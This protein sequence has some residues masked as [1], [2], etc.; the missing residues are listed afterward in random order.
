VANDHRHDECLDEEWIGSMIQGVMKLGG[1]FHR[2]KLDLNAPPDRVESVYF[3][4]GCL[5]LFKI[6]D[7]EAPTIVDEA[8]F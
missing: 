2:P 5:R 7:D 3:T 8:D 4:W 1:L 6:G